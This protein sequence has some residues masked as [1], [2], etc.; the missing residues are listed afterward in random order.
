MIVITTQPWTT[1]GTVARRKTGKSPQYSRQPLSR[2]R[3]GSVA[4]LL[5]ALILLAGAATA[6]DPE[7]ERVRKAT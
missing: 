6:K 1:K 2:S 7:I 3:A 5:A 4:P